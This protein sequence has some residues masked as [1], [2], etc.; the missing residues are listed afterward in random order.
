MTDNPKESYQQYF[1][2]YYFTIKGRIF[3]FFA[4]IPAT[5]YMSITFF[6]SSFM[7]NYIFLYIRKYSVNKQEQV[8]QSDKEP[9]PWS[10]NY[11]A[12][13]TCFPLIPGCLIPSMECTGPLVRHDMLFFR[14]SCGFYY[15]LAL[16]AYLA[17][18][19]RRE[20]R[21]NTLTV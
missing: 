5:W 10:T 1:H 18:S 13:E 7:N 17:R 20:G 4:Q 15:I 8:L 11:M 2:K 6:W 9:W 12:N 19:L 16:M 21:L 14:S 3:F